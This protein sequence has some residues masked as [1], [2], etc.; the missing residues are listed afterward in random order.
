MDMDK[1]TGI[2]SV[3]HPQLRSRFCTLTKKIMILAP[4]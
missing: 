1:N 3:Y 4:K 2:T